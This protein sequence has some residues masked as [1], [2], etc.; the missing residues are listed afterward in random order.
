VTEQTSAPSTWQLA[1]WWVLATMVA[2]LVG[3]ILGILLM[4]AVSALPPL[5]EDRVAMLLV[6]LCVGLV[7]GVMQQLVMRGYI[8]AAQR[9][10]PVTLAGYLAAVLVVVIG[11]A[12]MTLLPAPLLFAVLGGAIGMCQWTMLRRLSGAWLWPP[13]TAAGFVS[14]A[15]LAYNPAHTLIELAVLGALLAGLA[16]APPAAVLTWVVGQSRRA[17]I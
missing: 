6:L 13:A 15:W 14:F 17:A 5:N 12:S 9:W 7:C 1:V 16:A 4:F 2:W 8:P 11:N 3:L 10:I